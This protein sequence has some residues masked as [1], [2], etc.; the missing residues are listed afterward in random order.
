MTIDIEK[1]IKNLVSFLKGKK[2]IVSTH[3]LA[4]VDGVVSALAF[5]TFLTED[6]KQH[7]VDI[8]IPK[9]TKP[10]KQVLSEINLIFKQD[11]KNSYFVGTNPE[12]I[13]ITDTNNVDKIAF[14]ELEIDRESIKNNVI[15][16]DHHS[17]GDVTEKSLDE[18]NIILEEY[19]SSTE[20]ILEFYRTFDLNINE[21]F[22]HLFSAGILTDT[23]N[24]R[25]ANNDT[26]ERFNFL[27]QKGVDFQT[28]KDIVN[29]EI[30][31]PKKIANIKGAQRS[32]LIRFDKWLLCKTHISNY[33]SSV[34]SSLEHL[35]F[36]IVLVI[37]KSKK[38]DSY[39]ITARANH[40]VIREKE[41]DIGHLFSSLSEGEFLSGGGHS[42]A[43][44]ISGKG[45]LDDTLA[46]IMDYFKKKLIK[47]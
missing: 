14:D 1:K 47:N 21:Y 2:I 37:S 33:E 6:L 30:E 20:I 25:H 26:F 46:K 15:F 41:I 18:F 42:G 35:G 24:L 39:R 40:N 9:C 31:L 19:T 45:N 11:I 23:G 27:L 7:E 38:N 8:R 3:I 29:V 16:I 32:E 4:D 43:A 17:K 10:T 13:I 44:T 34:A 5:K 12:L 28:L 36:D 22:S